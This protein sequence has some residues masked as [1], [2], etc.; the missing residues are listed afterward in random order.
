M[1]SNCKK[2]IAMSALV[3]EKL[4]DIGQIVLIC[5][6]WTAAAFFFKTIYRL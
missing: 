3:V 6:I 1:R 5:R 4:Q 2:E